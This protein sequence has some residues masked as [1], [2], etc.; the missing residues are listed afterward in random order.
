MSP[1]LTTSNFIQRA[2]IVHGER[3]NYSSV[4]YTA[5]HSKV[6]IVCKIH[7]GFNQTPDVH[8][9]SKSGCPKC[10]FE[11]MSNDRKIDNPEFIKRANKIHRGKYDYS[12][13]EYINDTTKLK[14]R[15]SEHGLFEQTPNN[16]LRGCGCPDCGNTKKHTNISFIEKAKKVHGNHYDYSLVNYTNNKTKVSIHCLIHGMFTQIP[17]DH[18]KGQGCPGCANYGFDRT[19][20]GFLYVL[21]SEC[22]RYMKIGITNKPEQ[23]HK[24]LARTTPLSFE[25][26]ELIEGQGDQIA[27][28][29]KELLSCYQPAEFTET[30]DGSTEWRL[31]N[32]SIRHSGNGGFGST[33]K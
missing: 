1:R 10:K 30:F 24:Q 3:Y 2:R 14:I 16:H 21:R 15:C 6:V 20:E 33:G 23:R 19:K 12:S 13:A 26:V 25:C 31:W 22:G 11:K 28:L 8:L 17:S 5:M 4:K 29:E 18:M 7:G 27:D 9:N 32:D